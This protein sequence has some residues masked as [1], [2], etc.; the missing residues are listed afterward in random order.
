MCLNTAWMPVSHSGSIMKMLNSIDLQDWLHCWS[1]VLIVDHEDASIRLTSDNGVLF[2]EHLQ[3]TGGLLVLS[4]EY[5]GIITRCVSTF[6]KLPWATHW[7]FVGLKLGVQWNY[8][9]VCQHLPEASMKL[10]SIT[11]VDWN[12]NLFSNYH[13]HLPEAACN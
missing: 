4:L 2:D 7:G 3:L 12:W 8:Q 6:Q 1:W 5:N 9:T 10:L 13:T 11:N